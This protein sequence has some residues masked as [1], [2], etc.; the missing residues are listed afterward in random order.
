MGT[1][2]ARIL[3]VEDH[4]DT[5]RATEKLLKSMGYY[6]RCAASK[7]EA[8]SLCGD[9]RFD[10]LLADLTLPDGSGLDLM[11]ELRER[12]ST[13]RG[14]ALTGRG[15]QSDVE[16]TRAVGYSAHLLKPV[17]L[18]AMVETIERVLV[19]PGPDDFFSTGISS[20]SL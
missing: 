20:L 10:V 7:N 14:I 12:R 15:L 5:R 17:D 1:E 8:L 13:L 16:D 6:V 19:E 11:T 18:S 2:W 9:E 3:V 4:A